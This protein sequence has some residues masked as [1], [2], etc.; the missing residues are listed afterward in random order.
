MTVNYREAY[1]IHASN[2][3]LFNHESPI[4]GETFVTRKIT[5]A[6][7]AIYL[8][9]QPQ[10]WLGNL[11]AKRDWG[12]AKD[13][14]EG[15]WRIVQHETADDFVLATGKTNTVRYF[16]EQAFKAVGI[17]IQ[18]SGKGVQEEGHDTKTGDLL[19]SID[20]QYFRPTEVELLKGDPSKAKAILGWEATT[21]LKDLITE[22]VLSDLEVIER[23]TKYRRIDEDS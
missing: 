8:G 7:A 12:H 10:L 6:V 3:I 5:R 11:D 9:K 19:V 16:V 22:M 21:Q 23:E 4:R 1:D 20:P 17:D 14:V 18:W 15:M 2:G 13:Y